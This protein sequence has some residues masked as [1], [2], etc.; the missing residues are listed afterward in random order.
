LV[1]LVFLHHSLPFHVIISAGCIQHWVVARHYSVS[2]FRKLPY[3][4]CIVK[5]LA[6][7]IWV[8]PPDQ[9]SP[10]AKQAYTRTQLGMIENIL[11]ATLGRSVYFE[12]VSSWCHHQSEVSGND[13]VLLIHIGSE[14]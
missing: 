6:W 2:G 3:Y 11:E 10:K 13:N 1:Q 5:I 12:S 4:N 7:G 8:P 9:I 14:W